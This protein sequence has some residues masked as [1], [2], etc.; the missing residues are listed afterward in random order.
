MKGY[1]NGLGLLIILAP[2]I[3]TAHFLEE[4][5]RF[6]AWFNAHVHNGITSR[7]FWNVNISALVITLVVMVIELVEPSFFSA[8][9][10]VFW[11]SF[12]MLAN[13]IFHITGALVDR[14][15]MPGLVT[16]IIL[17]LPFY[18]LVVLRLLRKRRLNLRMIIV[19]AILG[20]TLMLVH[21]YLIV[22]RGSRLF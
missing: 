15:Y 17:Y 1:K 4:S 7:L 12:L 21:G 9:L 8:A 22:F 2:F 13:T 20:S 19:V 14:A 3:F 16:A 5:P 6:V 11:F 10:I 18:F